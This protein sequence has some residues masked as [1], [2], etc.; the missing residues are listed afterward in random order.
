MKDMKSNCIIDSQSRSQSSHIPSLL[1]SAHY[2]DCSTCQNLVHANI[3]DHVVLKTFW[4]CIFFGIPGGA[5]DF[6][7]LAFD[8]WH[9]RDLKSS[10][11]RSHKFYYG[12]WEKRKVSSRRF[13][14]P[15]GIFHCLGDECENVQMLPFKINKFPRVV[16]SLGQEMLSWLL[17]KS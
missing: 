12:L 10:D 5:I 11:G 9:A 3:T 13:L 2:Q 1:K 15:Q 7:F 16:S 6:R 14:F 4:L 8:A 17:F